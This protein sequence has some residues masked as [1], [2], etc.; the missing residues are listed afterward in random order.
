MSFTRFPSNFKIIV[1]LFVLAYCFCACVPENVKYSDEIMIDHNQADFRAIFNYQDR[2]LSDSLYPYF[3][4]SNPS[5]RYL[6]VNAFASIQSKESIDSIA[7]L[8]ED[9]NLEVRAAAVYALGQIGTAKSEKYIIQ[10]FKSQDTFDV[11][12]VCNRN[13]LEAIGKCGSE[14]YLKALSTVKGYRDTDT[15]L[16]EGQC[17]GIY[18]YATRGMTIPDGTKKM[19]EVLN[20]S[21]IPS[22]TKLIAANYLF[23]AKNIDLAPYKFQLVEFLSS[24]DPKIRMT[25]ATALGKTQDLEMLPYLINRLNIEEDYRVKSNIIRAFIHFPY[26]QVIETILPLINDQNPQ[27]VK[28]ALNYLSNSGNK[29]DALIYRQYITDSLN[30]KTK[31]GLYKV[32]LSNL[33]HYY[34]NTRSILQ[35]EILELIEKTSD[36]YEKSNYIEALAYN[37]RAYQA[38]Y[39]LAKENDVPI[40]GTTCATALGTLLSS[41]NFVKVFK[42]QST[43]T[44]KEIAILLRN[45]IELGD[46]GTMSAAA[47]AIYNPET[48]LKEIIDSTQYLLNAKNNLKL[49]K[50]IETYNEINRALCFL[51]DREYVKREFGFNHP[52]D[53]TALNNVSDSTRIVVKTSK[54]NFSM[55]LFQNKAPGT[56]ANFLNLVNAD[57]YDGNIIHRVVPNFVVQIGCPRGDGYGGLD[58]SIRSELPQMYYMDEGYV[59]MAS[60]GIHTEGTQWFVTH[61]PTP[62]LDGRYTIFAKITEGMDVVLDLEIGDKILDLVKL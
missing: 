59:G 21:N 22:S 39:D 6:A 51:Q 56:V 4:S 43:K 45:L 41:E 23:R 30:N 13:I 25:I 15:L 11:N 55:R 19:V 14:S 18:R 60:S 8:L 28:S 35:T 12:N 33:P 37:P 53:W 7:T 27:V 50:D 57:F 16:I 54:G 34:T 2:L 47:G 31:A 20:N 17:R 36:P 29:N 38:I 52:I 58:Y 24:N 61:S 62:H 42:Y 49:P 46:S 32:V 3:K 10:A 26:I 1:A 40:I 5:V 9:P 44:R 48:Q